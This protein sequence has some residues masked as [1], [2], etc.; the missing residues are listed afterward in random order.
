MRPI[1]VEPPSSSRDSIPRQASVAGCPC[2]KGALT[3]PSAS[4]GRGLRRGLLPPI[5]MVAALVLALVPVAA[6]PRAV[7]V[8]DGP[9]LD[10]QPAI[11]RQEPSGRL[12]VVF[13]RLDRATLSG[14]LYSSYSDTAGASW[15][16]PQ[17]VVCSELSERHPA[18]VQLGAESYA[19]Y[20]LVGAGG[21]SDYRIHRAVSVDG[22]NWEA[23]GE[24]DLGWP[25]PGEINPSVVRLPDGTLAMA[26][27]RFL[28]RAYLSL[29][30]DAGATWDKSRIFVTTQDA[31]LPR[32]AYRAADGRYIVTFQ[33]NP[34]DDRLNLWA[35]TTLDPSDWESDPIPVSLGR[36]T[37]D[38]FPIVLADGRVAVY[39]A[40]QVGSVPDLFTRTTQ[41]FVSWSP[42]VRITSRPTTYDTQPHPVL[43]GE[44]ETVALVWPRQ[45][46]EQ[47]Y[48]DHDVWFAPSVAVAPIA[49]P[50]IFLPIGYRATR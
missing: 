44:S 13:E 28:G 3:V 36:N 40:R 26:Y 19:L 9:E 38:S 17:P 25:D 46:S 30:R 7:S 8:H 29:S 41:E 42:E 24:I 2:E 32:I 21:R 39:Y 37:H 1:P 14:D 34:G 35:K 22:V 47:P 45:Q 27:H 33:T 12:L 31:A 23:Q 4:P 48:V 16:E 43:V 15:S 50:A 49:H 10:Y 5:G 20:Y 11:I 6:L 18:L